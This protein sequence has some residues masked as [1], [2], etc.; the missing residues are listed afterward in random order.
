MVRH[1]GG[2]EHFVRIERNE[3]TRSIGVIHVEEANQGTL[4]NGDDIENNVTRLNKFALDERDNDIY[5]HVDTPYVYNEETGE[6][7]NETSSL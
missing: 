6:I 7:Q 5:F 2:K 1:E 4:F 3:L